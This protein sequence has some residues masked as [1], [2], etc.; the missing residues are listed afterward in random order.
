MLYAVVV[1]LFTVML[2]KGGKILYN[3]GKKMMV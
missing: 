2:H 1:L 3:E